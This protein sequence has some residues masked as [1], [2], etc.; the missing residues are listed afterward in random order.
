MRLTEAPFVPPVIGPATGRVR[1]QPPFT[2]DSQGTPRCSRSSCRATG[3]PGYSA[4][5]RPVHRH[6]LP[7]GE[8]SE[9]PGA[10]V[11]RAPQGRARSLAGDRGRVG[12]AGRGA[13]SYTHLTLP[14]IY[15]V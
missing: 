1:S 12:R 9:P 7:H 2:W 6:G 3:E 8:G 14:T 5:G 11:V 4:D 10:A 13:V 15:S